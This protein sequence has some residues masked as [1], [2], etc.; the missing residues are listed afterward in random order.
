M[1]KIITKASGEKEPFDAKKLEESL[2]RAGASLKAVKATLQEIDR[3]SKPKMKSDEVF[4]CSL[5]ILRKHDVLVAARYSL[6]RAI[7]ELGPTGY[8]FERYIA[9][10]L[11]AYGYKTEVSVMAQ[12]KCVPQ[13][14]DVSA[15]KGKTHFLIECKYHN[16]RGSRSDLKVAM[17]TQARFE[18]VRAGALLAKG[19]TDTFHQPWLVTNTQVTSEA[20]KYAKC[21]GMKIL[22][23]KYPARGSLEQLIEAKHL[24]PIT[25][26][27]SMHRAILN[28]FIDSQVLLVEDILPYSAIELAQRFGLKKN[29]AEQLYREA[30][31]ICQ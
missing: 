11:N 21:M 1:D 3:Q 10:I 4:K 18:D 26:L 28:K 14:I 13:E 16:S 5:D 17:Y 29:I 22:A 25:I 15:R 23:W 31:G 7:M 9:R 27:P 8:V 2:V 12:G 6:K 19:P 24:Y 30:H 20:L